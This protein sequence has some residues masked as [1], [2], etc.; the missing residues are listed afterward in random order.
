MR[1]EEEDIA[2][3]TFTY[4]THKKDLAEFAP[5]HQKDT[6]M[7]T[8]A[9]HPTGDKKRDN[10]RITRAHGLLKSFPGNDRFVFMLFENGNQYLVEFPNETTGLTDDLILALGKLIGE[11]NLQI[12]TIH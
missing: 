9:I 5:Q 3:E 2:V 12:A 7:I 10:R 4:I 1:P 11:E 6:R 8:L